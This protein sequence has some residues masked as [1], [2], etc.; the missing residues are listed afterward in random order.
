FF[1]TGDEIYA[2]EALGQIESWIEQNPKLQ[3]VNWQSSLEIA[4]RSMSW[5]WTLFLLLEAE[6][7]QEAQLR[8]IC[9]SLFAQ[10][11]HVYRY[12]SV[13][14]SPNTHLIGET[15]ALFIAGILFPELPRAE[16]WRVFATRTLIEEMKRQVM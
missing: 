4:I 14:S 13:F 2:R 8:R 6:S 15:A 16:G 9:R 1:L 7:L 5:L 12:P 10:L 11:D 3:G